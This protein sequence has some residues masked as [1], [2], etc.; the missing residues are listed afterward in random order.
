MVQPLAGRKLAKVQQPGRAHTARVDDLTMRE[1]HD[2][3][4]IYP[5]L[6]VHSRGVALLWARDH[7]YLPR[8]PMPDR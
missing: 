6:H 2:V 8:S 1:R 7:R 5:E 4:T 3:A